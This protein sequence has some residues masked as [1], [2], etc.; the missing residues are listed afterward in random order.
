MDQSNFETYALKKIESIN[1]DDGDNKRFS[2]FPFWRQILIK[3]PELIQVCKRRYLA[4]SQNKKQ[5][6]SK[7]YDIYTYYLYLL[8]PKLFNNEYKES[9]SSHDIPSCI[10][11]TDRGD[12]QIESKFIGDSPKDEDASYA[13]EFSCPKLKDEYSESWSTYLSQRDKED[14][15]AYDLKRS[16]SKSLS[17]KCLTLTSY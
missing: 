5:M 7:H 9:Q 16:S 17:K 3:K 1:E 11:K 15:I 12:I 10:L 4:T 13:F 6:N 8:D 14:S 2:Y